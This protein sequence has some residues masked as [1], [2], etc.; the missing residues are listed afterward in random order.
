MR[1]NG[2]FTFKDSGLATLDIF[3]GGNVLENNRSLAATMEEL[4]RELNNHPHVA[5]VRQCGMILAIE[6]I[7]DKQQRIPY[8]WQERRGL[9]VYQHALKQG[10][11]L[12]PLGNVIY[13][14]P[15]YVITAEELAMVIRVAREGIDE[16]TV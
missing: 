9:K 3:S 5:E 2:R 8:P 12:R 11:L 7:K 16:A 6:M 13:V 14:M 4:T 1:N 10:V 15:P